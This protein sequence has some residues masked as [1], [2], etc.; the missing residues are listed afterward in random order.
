LEAWLGTGL[1]TSTGKKWSARRKL[2]TPT[3]HFNILKQFV[4]T[5]DEHADTLVQNLKRLADGQELDIHPIIAAYALDVICGRTYDK[6]LR[7]SF[8]IIFFLLLQ[9][10]QW[11]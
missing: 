8:K 4:Q 10:L 6:C 11:E 7:K 1:L 5:F 2:I 9:K 3:F